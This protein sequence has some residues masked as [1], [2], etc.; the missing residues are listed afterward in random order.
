MILKNNK[1]NSKGV[2]LVEMLITVLLL[3][4]LAGA[5]APSFQAFRSRAVVRA[6]AEQMMGF[7]AENRLRAIKENN[8]VDVSFA[9]ITATLSERVTVSSDDLSDITIEPRL[10]VLEDPSTAGFADF[11]LEGYALRFGI[12]PAGQ[13]FVCFPGTEGTK[14][15]GGYPPCDE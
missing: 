7:L 11:S 8:A 6:S 9:E 5:A 4:I 10:G 14:S 2:T 13:G 15:P 12:T 1:H 3:A